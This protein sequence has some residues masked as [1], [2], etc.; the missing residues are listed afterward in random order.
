MESLTAKSAELKITIETT[1]KNVAANKEALATA[2]AQREK[3][4]KAFHDKEL[5]QIQNLENMKAALTVMAKHDNAAFPQLSPSFLQ[6]SDSAGWSSD[7]METVRRALRSQSVFMQDNSVYTPAYE[8]QSGEILG[9]LKQMKETMENDLKEAQKK[10]QLDAAA[11]DELRRAK[12][13]R[14]R[15]V[16]KR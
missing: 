2:T 7:D 10:E 4:G 12:L 8:S 16:R 11:F 13:Q 6:T 9:V 15:R 3:D 1:E 5:D 14:S